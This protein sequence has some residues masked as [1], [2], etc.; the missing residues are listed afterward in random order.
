[1]SYKTFEIING[2]LFLND[3]QPAEEAKDIDIY[4]DADNWGDDVE[5]GREPEGFRD[6]SF[7][8]E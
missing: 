5:Y 6:F 2:E 7:N 8:Y 1:M 4:L 3:A